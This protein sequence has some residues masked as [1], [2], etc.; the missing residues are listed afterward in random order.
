MLVLDGY[1]VCASKI[2]AE[3]LAMEMD[4]M[5]DGPQQTRCLRSAALPC[6]VGIAREKGFRAFCRYMFA[7]VLKKANER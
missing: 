2:S 5:S 6:C 7:V 3:S 1:A 4:K